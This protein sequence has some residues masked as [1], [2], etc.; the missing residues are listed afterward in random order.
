MNWTFLYLEWSWDAFKYDGEIN[1]YVL[2]KSWLNAFK[3]NI[4]NTLYQFYIY[5]YTRADNINCA[6]LLQYYLGKFE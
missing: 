1:D 4:Q 6:T 3:N 2:F 5:G